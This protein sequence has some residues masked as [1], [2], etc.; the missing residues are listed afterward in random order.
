MLSMEED[1]KSVG[2]RYDPL[3][4]SWETKYLF[5]VPYSE[6][7]QVITEDLNHVYW[8]VRSELGCLR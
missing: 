3:W 8:I 1:L 5:V 4:R 7:I 6:I 2:G